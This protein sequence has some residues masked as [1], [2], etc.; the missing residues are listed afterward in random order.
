MKKYEYVLKEPYDPKWLENLKNTEL[1]EY[2]FYEK[3][4]KLSKRK[5]E[6]D[7][8]SEWSQCCKHGKNLHHCKECGVR[9]EKI[10]KEKEIDPNATFGE[11]QKQRILIYQTYG[12]NIEKSQ[13]EKRKKRKLYLSSLN[14]KDSRYYTNIYCSKCHKKKVSIEDFDKDFILPE[15]HVYALS[16]IVKKEKRIRWSDMCVDCTKNKNNN[17]YVKWWL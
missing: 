4:G 1:V 5:R 15:N 13:S 11:K 3:T 12:K 9:V 16:K 8:W 10:Y 14:Y 7:T 2:T 6:Y 17:N